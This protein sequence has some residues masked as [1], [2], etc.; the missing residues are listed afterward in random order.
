VWLTDFVGYLPMPAGE[1]H[2][3]SLTTDYNAE[4]IEQIERHAS[5]R[6]RAIFIGDPEDAIPMSFGAGLPD[7]RTWTEQHYTFAGYVPGF[8]PRSVQ[9]QAAIKAEL[10]YGDAPLCLISVGGSGVGAPLLRRVIDALPRARELVAGLRT[11]A[12][13]GPRIDPD[14]LPSVEGLEIRGYVHEL[15]RHLA[16]CDVAVVQGG[17]TTTMELVTAQRPFISIPL[18]SH[19]EQRFHVRHRL[20]RYGATTWLNYEDATPDTLAGALATA[21]G[22]TPT[23]RPV[24][25]GGASAAA[26]LIAELL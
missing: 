11:V 23:Y 25:P 17:L 15:Y 22:S 21:L 2:E 20:D 3:A 12:V 4:M 7:I 13:A 18:A 9:N 10:G 26:S 6:D 19:F 5:I 24:E 8:D 14:S 16:A 1:D